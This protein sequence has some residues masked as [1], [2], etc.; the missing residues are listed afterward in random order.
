VSPSAPVVGVPSAFTS[1]PLASV[2][3]V[4]PVVV[5]V[6]HVVSPVA[7]VS[8][9]VPSAVVVLVVVTVVP[10]SVVVVVVSALTARVESNETNNTLKNLLTVFI[11]IK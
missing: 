7:V 10:S 5:S 4:V 11:V 1:V 8:V 2:P 9:V 6:V 3:V